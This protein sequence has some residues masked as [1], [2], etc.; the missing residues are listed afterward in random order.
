MGI[1]RAVKGLG[2]YFLGLDQIRRANEI[3]SLKAGDP[4]CQ[5]ISQALSTCKAE[6]LLINISTTVMGVT[7]V[8]LPYIAY[9]SGDGGGSVTAATTA[10]QLTLVAYEL[11]RKSFRK[12]IERDLESITDG[13]IPMPQRDRDEIVTKYSYPPMEQL[14]RIAEYEQQ[15]NT[16]VKANIQKGLNTQVH[17]SSVILREFIQE[18]GL[19]KKVKK[20]DGA[21]DERAIV[22][23]A[24]QCAKGYL[25]DPA[26]LTSAYMHVS[27]LKAAA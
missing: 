26:E 11:I 13:D 19:K 16:R 9:F 20:N 14:I 7:A 18:N 6:S 1:G 27:N 5:R 8:S 22:E 15:T 2:N 10:S 3:R 25:L 17:L 23:I 21:Y 4:R 24:A 12:G